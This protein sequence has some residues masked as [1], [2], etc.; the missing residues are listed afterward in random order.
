MRT[1]SSAIRSAYREL[2]EVLFSLTKLSLPATSH[3]VYYV[4]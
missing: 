2:A 1:R 3:N 4:K